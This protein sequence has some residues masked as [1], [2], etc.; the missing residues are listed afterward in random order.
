MSVPPAPAGGR[1]IA[2]AGA[3][4][5]QGRRHADGSGRPRTADRR[6]PGPGPAHPPGERLRRLRGGDRPARRRLEASIARSCAARAARAAWLPAPEFPP[7]LPITAQRLAI[8]AAVERHPVVVVRGETGSGKTTQLPKICLAAGRG[9]AGWIGHTQPRRIAA[10][11]VAARIARE[12]G[13][14][15]GEAVGSKV[16]FRD[17]VGPDTY[18]KVM[19]DGILVA[20]IGKDRLLEAYDTLILD[21]AHERSLN[22]DLLLGHVKE[23]LAHR[24]DLR[25][26]VSSATLDTQRISDFF[27]DAPVI[28]VSGR[29]Y[30]G[31]GPPRGGG[32]RS[33]GPGRGG[34]GGGPVGREGRSGRTSSSSC[35]ASATSGRRPGPLR[36]DRA[37]EVLPLYARLNHAQQE[38]IF[39]PGERRRVVLATN[40]AETSLTVPRIRFV[41]RHRARP[42]QPVQLSHQGPAPPRRAG[43]ARLRRAAPRA[44][45]ADRGRAR[46]CGSTRGRTSRAGRDSPRPR[47]RRT[48]LASVILRMA[49]S[50]LGRI[51]EFA[52]IDPPDRR[53]VTDGYR[54]LRE[55]G[56][57]DAEDRV[58]GIGRRIRP[59][60][61]RS[62]DRPD[63]PGRRRARLRCRDPGDRGRPERR[64]PAR[65][66]APRGAVR[67]APPTAASADPRSDFM[68]YLNLWRFL[69]DEGRRLRS[70]AWRRR[71][72]ELFLSLRAAC[73]SGGTSIASSSSAAREMGLRPAPRS[74]T[75]AQI[76]RAVLAGCVAHVGVRAQGREYR[77]PRD[78]TFVLSR[79]SS[80][81]PAGVHWIVAADLVETS[82]VFAHVAARIRPQWIERSARELVTRE[83]FEPHFDPERGEVM[84]LERVVLYGLTVVPRR[85]VRFAPVDPAGARTI[86]ISEGLANGGLV[87]GGR[88]RAAQPGDAREDAGSSSDGP[89]GRISWSATKPAPASSRP[90]FPR[91]SRGERRFRRWHDALPDSERLCFALGDLVRPEPGCRPRGSFPDEIEVSGVP[92]PLTYRF[93]PED[94]DDGITARI[95]PA[96]L[97]ALEAERFEWLVPGRR[98]EKAVALLRTLPR[99][100]RRRIVPLRDTARRCLAWP[101]LPAN[102]FAAA[103]AAALH[104]IAGVEVGAADFRPDLVPGHLRMRFEVIGA[105]GQV[106]G[107]GRDLDELKGRFHAEAARSFTRAA[108][109]TFERE[110]LTTWCFRRPSGSCRR[111]ARR[112]PLPGLPPPSR[113]RGSS[114]ALRLFDAPRRAAAGHPRRGWLAS[115]CC[116]SAGSCAPFAGRSAERSGSRFVISRRRLP[117]G[118]VRVRPP[119]A[120]RGTSWRSCSREPS[121]NAVSR[122]GPGFEAGASSSGAS[123]PAR[124][125]WSRPPSRSATSRIGSSAPGRRRAGRGPP[126]SPARIRNRSPTS[127][128]TSPF[129]VYRGFLADTPLERLAELP[130][131]LEA[132]RGRLAKLPRNPARDLES[133]RIVRAVW[134]PVRDE[135]RAFARSGEP[136]DAPRVECRWMLEELRGLAVHAGDGHPP[137]GCRYSGSSARGAGRPVPSPRRA[138]GPGGPRSLR[139]PAFGQG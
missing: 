127:T 100:I 82:T 61:R 59:P 26:I 43:L 67:R 58:T 45:R 60:A 137:S 83:Y 49:A 5:E 78:R 81:K 35:P 7:E 108:E 11:S 97:G 40:V 132:A 139:A 63:D 14:R 46:A 15:V 4:H 93:A 92:V 42:Y 68:G 75:Y 64:G 36:A 134:T 119:G 138:P 86:F 39:R 18:V 44:V 55:L 52:F 131:Y 87:T 107:N 47:V 38:R 80:V 22:I 16:R 117:R 115:R 77:G 34:A 33:R 57:F 54:L 113:N 1:R 126:S 74:A 2:P 111:G 70:A 106:L 51:D 66:A 122:T 90:G 101:G 112:R 27:G 104:E 25:V 56:A 120:R 32:L 28:D 9:A 6:G 73:A 37:F 85:R 50:G 128:S 96:V 84:A 41:V 114:V 102:G 31:R 76:H 69:N 48:N 125:A 121:P 133:T 124:R 98:E 24:P 123:T 95:A 103:L 10:R 71:C 72:Q 19:T 30:P 110:G 89:G 62:A 94:P 65:V 129:L 105:H 99:P 116:G 13:G 118:P 91:K 8:A 88:V 17:E 136:V 53:F 21:E 29:T 12:L 109:R 3:I 79:G 23:V 135:L 20:E 130:R